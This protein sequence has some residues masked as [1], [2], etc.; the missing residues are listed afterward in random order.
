MICSNAVIAS[1]DSSE[2]EDDRL[3]C[4][5]HFFNVPSM[6]L[7]RILE[8]GLLSSVPVRILCYPSGV[9]DIK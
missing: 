9:G 1:C 6:L 5:Y 4:E 3:Y 2:C 8:N 7:L